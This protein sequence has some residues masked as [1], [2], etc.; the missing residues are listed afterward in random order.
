MIFRKDCMCPACHPVQADRVTVSAILTVILL[1]NPINTSGR[2]FD[3]HVHG[4]L[5]P[6]Y[7]DSNQIRISNT[8][9][10]F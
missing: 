2:H 10:Q 6:I 7:W 9:H 5:L 8:M 4:W 3:G 1:M